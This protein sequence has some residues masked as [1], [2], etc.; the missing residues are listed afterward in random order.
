MWEYSPPPTGRKA[1]YVPETFPTVNTEQPVVCTLSVD[2]H[3]LNEMQE[4]L[5][6]H[7]N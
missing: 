6:L 2:Y 7:P 5:K 3:N 4:E 1:I